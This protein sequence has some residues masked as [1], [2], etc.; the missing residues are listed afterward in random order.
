[1]LGAAGHFRIEVEV[2]PSA[3]H[4]LPAGHAEKSLAVIAADRLQRFKGLRRSVPVKPSSILL[5]CVGVWFF[6][7]TGHAQQQR[8]ARPLLVGVDRSLPVRGRPCQVWAE[9]ALGEGTP[10]PTQPT[11][12]FFAAAEVFLR[13]GSGGPASSPYVLESTLSKM[14]LIV[15]P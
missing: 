4:R 7:D 3:S 12:T 9:V 6:C 14:R 8:P 13:G 11:V 2:A 10:E 1:M 5:V 15:G